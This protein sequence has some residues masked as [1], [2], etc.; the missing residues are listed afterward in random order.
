M[1]RLA[2]VITFFESEFAW[3]LCIW[4]GINYDAYIEKSKELFL[5]IPPERIVIGMKRAAE[6]WMEV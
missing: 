2:E 5:D 6:W 3:R 4:T 1:D